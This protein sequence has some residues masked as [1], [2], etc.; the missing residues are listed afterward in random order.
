[1][2]VKKLRVLVE[3]KQGQKG[4]STILMEE[5]KFLPVFSSNM[6]NSCITI[7]LHNTMEFAN[8]H[9]V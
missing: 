1:M 8:V 5:S 9:S 2:N 3:D 7:M 4:R 6:S